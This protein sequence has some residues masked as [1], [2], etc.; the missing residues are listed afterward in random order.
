MPR[1]RFQL[2]KLTAPTEAQVAEADLGN[3]AIAGEKSAFT[4]LYDAYYDQIYRYVLYR[5][6]SAKDAEDLAHRDIAL[7][8]GKTEG[9]ARVIQHRALVELRRILELEEAA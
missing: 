7:S 1:R 2:T 3:R 5:V 8:M 6:S 4:A 9:A